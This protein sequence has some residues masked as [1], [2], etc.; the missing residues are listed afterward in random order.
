MAMK[1]NNAPLKR[2]LLKT[3]IFILLSLSIGCGEETPDRQ[4]CAIG[5]ATGYLTS[6]DQC[7]ILRWPAEQLPILISQEAG[8]PADV[9][10]AITT[11]ALY[12]EGITGMRLFNIQTAQPVV[13]ESE[14]D[15]RFNIFGIRSPLVWTLSPINGKLEEPAKT[16]YYYNSQGLYRTNI[17]FN[18]DFTSGDRG[19]YDLFTIA[20]HELGHVLGLDHDD[21]I[22]FG[23][24]IMFSQIN[25]E[26]E[27]RPTARDIQRIRELYQSR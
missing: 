5:T 11:A 4:A 24:S 9:A 14:T 26:E 8:T 12:W 17:Y 21:S 20:L 19:D 15:L 2:L 16:V 6:K 3:L 13:L 25:P 23:K 7:Q 22:E 10:T 27:R 18:E 1:K